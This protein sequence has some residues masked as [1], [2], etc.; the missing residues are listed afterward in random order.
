MH[1]LVGRRS[2]QHLEQLKVVLLRIP[3]ENLLVA[4]GGLD[5][6]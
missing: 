4:V 3:N 5:S 1:E 2:F 6:S